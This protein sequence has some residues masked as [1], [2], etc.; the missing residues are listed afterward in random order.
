MTISKSQSKPETLQSMIR[1]CNQP[2]GPVG[3]FAVMKDGAIF[4]MMPE[5]VHL[6]VGGNALAPARA[7]IKPQPD[8]TTDA[9]LRYLLTG[10]VKVWNHLIEILM[11]AKGNL[12]LTEPESTLRTAT[13]RFFQR[14][15]ADKFG[16]YREADA[17]TI[18]A[19]GEG[20]E[21]RRHT[22]RHHFFYYA[23][24]FRQYGGRGMLDII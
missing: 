8:K 15:L 24:R 11:V 21:F 12:F 10:E 18:C 23:R 6:H 17:K 20:G 2:Q 19:A 5:D 22:L 16:P 13:R 9:A 7:P 3:L 14:W 4:E 1:N